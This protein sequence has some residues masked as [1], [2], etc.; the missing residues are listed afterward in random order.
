MATSATTQLGIRRQSWNFVRHFLEMCVSMCIGGAA[1]NYLVFSGIPALTGGP[2][3]R[4]QL[5]ELSLIIIALLLTAPM[6]AWMLLRGMPWRPT[7]EMAAVAF[8]LA[9]GFIGLVWTGFVAESAL[10]ITFGRFCGLTCIGM[11]LVMLFRLDLY[12]GRSGQ[13]ARHHG[14]EWAG[15]P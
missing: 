2:N 9:F 8:G 10:Q 1:L 14:I 11:F 3:P 5:P 6:T 12:T 15:R 13:H 7:L 4:E